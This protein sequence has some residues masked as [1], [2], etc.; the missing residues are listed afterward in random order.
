MS[1]F[2]PARVAEGVRLMLSGLSVDLDSDGLR[3]TPERVA[4]AWAE[5][6]GGYAED[7]AKLFEAQFPSES[8]DELIVLSGISFHSTCEH[9][10]LPFSGVAHVGYLPSLA[11]GRVVGLSKLARVVDVFARRLQIQERMTRQIGDT[12]QKHLEPIGCGVIVQATHGCMVC[13]G[14]KKSGAQMTTSAL[15]GLF[16]EPALR[17]EFMGFIR[18]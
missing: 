7:P 2:D 15:Y 1:K 16:K 12:L 13:R 10:L 3:G 9:H 8:Y 5:I 6:L 11:K 18:R 17:A 4:R 14:V